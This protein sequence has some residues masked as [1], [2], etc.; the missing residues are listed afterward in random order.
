MYRDFVTVEDVISSRV[1]ADPLHLLDCCITSDGG[2]TLVLDSTDVR[3]ELNRECVQV[4]GHGEAPAY[5]DAGKL[6]SINMDL[7]YIMRLG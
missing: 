4:L 7:G 5:H 1:V 6:N 3:A 2:G